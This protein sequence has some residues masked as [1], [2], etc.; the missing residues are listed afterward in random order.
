MMVEG[1]GGRCGIGS[2]WKEGCG[3]GGRWWYG[4][5]W[6]VEWQRKQIVAT[7]VVVV[8]GEG[9]VVAEAMG[10]MSTTINNG[11]IPIM[12]DGIDSR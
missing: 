8:I 6:V 4:S 11:G 2:G 5:R 12:V 10:A 1:S 7:V 9:M 3:G